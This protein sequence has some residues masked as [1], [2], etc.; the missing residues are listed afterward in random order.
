MGNTD[1]KIIHQIR[2]SLKYVASKNQNAFMVD[3]KC[4]YK[5]ATLSAAESALD[6]LDVAALFG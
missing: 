5:A 1:L 6:E 3:L 2:S 4:V